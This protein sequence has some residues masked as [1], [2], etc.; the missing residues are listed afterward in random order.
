MGKRDKW[1]WSV[2]VVA[3]YAVGLAAAL[4]P[5][6][7]V[8]AGY[9]Q[10]DGE[11]WAMGKCY[12]DELC[13]AEGTKEHQCVGFWSMACGTQTNYVE[14]YE[15]MWYGSCTSWSEKNCLYCPR[16]WCAKAHFFA[17]MQNGA[18]TDYKCSGVVSFDN[19]CYPPQ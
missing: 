11:Y 1:I 18:C 8:G 14:A 5:P 17:A 6:P 2:A 3:V 9:G 10:C 7:S 19:V 13:L 15:P 12:K 16:F 4:W